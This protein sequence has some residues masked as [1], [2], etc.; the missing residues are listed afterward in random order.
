MGV[1]EGER[2]PPTCPNFNTL[3]V[4]EGKKKPP[5]CHFD[6]LGVVEGEK[7]PPTCHFDMLGVDGVVVEVEGTSIEESPERVEMTHWG[8]LRARGSPHHVIA[9]RQGH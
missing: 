1:I 3:G 6:M 7:K 2:K 4:V 8:S 5:T 9:T